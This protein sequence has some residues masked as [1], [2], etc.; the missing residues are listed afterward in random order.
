MD[1]EET[2]Q[3]LIGASLRQARTSQNLTLED[4]SAQLRLSEKQITALEDDDFDSFGSAMLTRGFIK[5]YA[6]LL[7]LDPEQF[8]DAHRKIAPHD[9]VQSI[10]YTSELD[11]PLTDSSASRH[12]KLIM[13]ISL[14][15]LAMIGLVTYLTLGNQKTKDQSE[16]ALDS[17]VTSNLEEKALSV[18]LPENSV[19]IVEAKALEAPVSNVQDD[20]DSKLSY[21]STVANNES[22]SVENLNSKND[23]LKAEASKPQVIIGLEKLTLKFTEESWVSIQDKNYKTILSKLGRAGDVE[24]VEGLAPLRVVIGNA[25]GTQVIIKNQK[26][27][28]MPYNKSNVVHMTLPLE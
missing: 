19:P 10:A 17:A 21:P 15:A 28:L 16:I 14:I 13:F 12:A 18:V 25:N 7:S 1:Q 20:R 6:R 8:L 24:D 9:Q 4:V 27:D 11:V 5:N 22:K 26:I 3:V 23:P 2:N